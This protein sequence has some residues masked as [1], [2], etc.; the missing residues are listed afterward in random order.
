MG[1]VVPI[2]GGVANGGTVPGGGPGA[3]APGVGEIVGGGCGVITCTG[4]NPCAQI[5]LSSAIDAIS[6]SGSAFDCA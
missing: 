2:G 1:G 3:G 6:I 5:L 4:C